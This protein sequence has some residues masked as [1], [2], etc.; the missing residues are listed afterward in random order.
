MLHQVERLLA[1]HVRRWGSS[2]VGLPHLGCG[3]TKPMQKKLHIHSAAEA[4]AAAT[5]PVID[6][7]AMLETGNVEGKQAVG[8]AVAEACERIGAF[9]VVGHGISETQQQQA[10]AAADQFFALPVDV[11][12]S[13]GPPAA[14]SAG[15]IRGYL[16]MAEESGSDAVEV[17]EAF[18]YG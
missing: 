18:S 13:V 5:V 6:I 11:K 15:F 9:D 2:N 3:S 7:S 10:R 8:K 1:R 17:K 14:A 16:G 4:A 12:R